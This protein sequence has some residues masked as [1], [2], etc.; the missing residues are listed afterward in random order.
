L[1]LDDPPDRRN[2]QP[3][4]RVDISA[5]ACIEEP[6]L[7]EHLT[8]DHDG[9]AVDRIL[10]ED[11]HERIWVPPSGCWIPANQVPRSVDDIKPSRAQ[12]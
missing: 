3:H 2:P 12:P 1:E 4:V 11:C 5:K 7:I 9:G 10:P 6:N 8:P